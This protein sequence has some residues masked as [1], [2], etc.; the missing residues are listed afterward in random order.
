MTPTSPLPFIAALKKDAD[1]FA[2]TVSLTAV[3]CALYIGVVTV[4]H[5]LGFWGPLESATAHTIGLFLLFW[6]ICKA[7]WATIDYTIFAVAGAL[8]DLGAALVNGVTES[9]AETPAPDPQSAGH[10]SRVP[11]RLSSAS[12]PR[13][14]TS[15]GAGPAEPTPPDAA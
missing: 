10:G 1:G 14:V 9:V 13:Q 4:G 12:V 6:M 7:V 5:W 8:T 15:D 2:D 11:S 3:L